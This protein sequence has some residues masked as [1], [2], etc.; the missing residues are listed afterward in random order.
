MLDE[1]IDAV[2]LFQSRSLGLGKKYGTWD[3]IS[4]LLFYRRIGKAQEWIYFTGLI[5]IF[6]GPIPSKL[7]FFRMSPPKS[8]AFF[9]QNHLEDLDDGHY[10]HHWTRKWGLLDWLGKKHYWLDHRSDL[11]LRDQSQPICAGPEHILDPQKA[12]GSLKSVY[13]LQDPHF[14]SFHTQWHHSCHGQFFGAAPPC[15]SSRLHHLINAKCPLTQRSFTQSE[16]RDQLL[17]MS[18]TLSG[19]MLDLARVWRVIFFSKPAKCWMQMES[20]DNLW[21]WL[22]LVHVLKRKECSRAVLNIPWGL[23]CCVWKWQNTP[24]ANCRLVAGHKTTTLLLTWA[25]YYIARNPRIEKSLGRATCPAGD[26]MLSGRSKH[27][28]VLRQIQSVVNMPLYNITRL[29]LFGNEDVIFFCRHTK[30]LSERF[31]SRRSS[32]ISQVQFFLFNRSPQ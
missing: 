14:M 28:L 18:G 10:F 32:T 5:V 12:C 13:F 4:G 8:P 11:V 26:L 2:R 20:S 9:T 23:G 19:R 17:T 22:N 1:I 16:L 31:T 29:D 30:K 25:L 27:L 24:A 6:F 3:E 21:F 7:A 15:D